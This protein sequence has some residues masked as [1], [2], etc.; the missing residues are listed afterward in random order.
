MGANVDVIFLYLVMSLSCYLHSSV[1][2]GQESELHDP[3]VRR[4]LPISWSAFQYT[5][6]MDILIEGY[7]SSLTEIYLT[8]TSL[9]PYTLLMN[10]S[11]YVSVV[12]IE[13]TTECNV[14]GNGTEKMCT[15][16]PGYS[17]NITMCYTYPPCSNSSNFCSCLFIQDDNIPVCEAPKNISDQRVSLKGYLTTN[18]TFTPDLLDP[19]STNYKAKES[20]LTLALLNAYTKNCNPL[21]VAV[22]GFSPGSVIASYRMLLAGPVS[23]TQLSSSNALVSQSL[24]SVTSSQLSTLGMVTIEP[25]QLEVNFGDPIQLVCQINETMPSV[26]WTLTVNNVTNTL[27]PGGENV[28][29]STQQMSSSTISVLTIAHASQYWEGKYSCQ[30]SIDG[31]E[32]KAKAVVNITLLPLEITIN[33]LQKSLTS[34]DTSQLQLECCVPYDEEN[35]N[36]TWTYD[37]LIVAALPAGRTDLNCYTLVPPRPTNDTNYTCTFMNKAGQQKS[38]VIPVTVIQATDIYCSVNVSNGITWNV[39]KAGMSASALCP[40]GKSGYMTRDCSAVGVWLSVQDNCISQQLQT[41]LSSVQALEQGLGIAQVNVPDIIQQMSNSSGTIVNNVAEVSTAVNI[42]GSISSM[43]AT[44][45]CTFDP[46]VVTK[47]LTLAS[48]LID[49]DFSPLWRSSTSPPASKM[50]QSVECFCQLLQTGNQSFE[51]DLENIQIKGNS[52]EQG[53]VG[54]DYQKNFATVSLSIDKQ[55][56]S[57]LLKQNNLKITSVVFSTIGNLLPNTFEKRNDSQLNSIVQSTSIKLSDS[58]YASTNIEMSFVVNTSNKMYSQHCVFWDFS[59]PGF[60]GSWSDAGC[61]SM[62]GTN[63]T[64]CSCSHLTSFAVLMSINVGSLALI[65]EITY[66]GLGVSI[67]SL[68]ICVFIEGFVWKTVTRTNISYFRHIS[69]INI[70]VSLL[71]ADVFFLSSAFPSIIAKQLICLS[72]TFLNHFFYLAL[73]FWTFAQSVMLLH[74]LLFVFHHLRK[75]IFVSLS[76]TA[77]YFFPAI[78]AAGTLL[79]YYPKGKYRHE[80]VCWLNPESGAIY[81]FAVPAGSIIVFNFLTLLVVIAKLSRPSVSEANQADKET[82]K[83]ILKA[84]VVLTPVFGLTWSFGFAL[85]TNLDDLT[86]QVFTYGFAGMNAFQGFFILLTCITEKKVR[87][88][89]F[90]KGS[91]AKTSTATTMSTSEAS[92]DHIKKK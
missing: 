55:T 31:L 59:L 28:N 74:Q 15:C 87:E 9:L 10:A 14:T 79:Y 65:E 64:F 7:G 22:L 17:W 24:S 78:I 47:F 3:R 33:P 5:Y 54:E 46:S 23:S 36:V 80:K 52:Y 83:S 73:F 34:K 16:N 19:S 29:V 77:G 18:E 56:I 38:N 61:T 75:R 30:I 84:V 66:A 82:A 44:Q 25:A 88:A 41:A 68:C 1:T 8:N 35:Y 37:N 81:A 57:S 2:N 27:F 60:G 89:L 45:N 85:L 40:L 50:L 91:P 86:R 26:N 76:F 53:S 6:Y 21:S 67:L 71:C 49:P 11:A 39:T 58:S 92:S 12:L 20:N 32:L 62:L 90:N 70:T 43:A 72:I 42:L 69:L 51:I 63:T 13:I 48:N 4:H